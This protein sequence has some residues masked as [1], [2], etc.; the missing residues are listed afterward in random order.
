MIDTFKSTAVRFA[1]GLSLR[2]LDTLPEQIG[3][4]ID[5]SEMNA[6]TSASDRESLRFLRY[7]PSALPYEISNPPQSPLTPLNPPLLRGKLKG[8]KGVYRK[9]QGERGGLDDVLIID[10]KGG[11]QVLVAIYYDSKNLYKVESNPLLI[12]IIRDEFKDFSDSMYRDNTWS[13]LGRSWLKSDYRNFDLIDISL[14]GPSPSG[15]F[16]ISED[17]RFTV[18]TFKEYIGHLKA[19]G[20]LSINLFILPPP[21]IE[22]RLINTIIKAMEELGIKDVANHIFAIRSWGSICFL[23]KRAPFTSEEIEATREFSKNRRFDLIHYPGIKEEETNIYI[24]M[25]S[26]E[27]FTA[28]KK[29]LNPETRV[30]FIDD[31]IF[32]VSPVRD[33]NPF[34]HYFLRLK[35]VSEIYKLM[36]GKWQYFIEEGYILPMVFIQV[37]FLSLILILLPAFSPPFSSPLGCESYRLSK[38]RRRGVKGWLG[39]FLV[40]I[41]RSEATEQFATKVHSERSEESHEIASATPRNDRGKSFLPYFA[42]LGI[43]FMFVEIALIQKII[44]PLENPSY[45]AAAVLTSILISSGIGSLLSHRVSLLRSSFVIILISLLI[46][47]YRA[48][49]TNTII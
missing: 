22:F 44:L 33:D 34:F 5:G 9:V 39:V 21:R 20:L 37:I 49:C 6:I 13:G 27:Y 3:F 8:G 29:M 38:G 10:P 31:Y 23:I 19:E 47:I 26:N 40:V 17:Y 18:E 45:A 41:A 48:C 25:P 24:K 35:N 11:L 42:L 43:G 7:L 1:P 15:S 12:K 4:S 28:F 16:G 46:I 32:D 30:K 2:Y 36:G 14:M